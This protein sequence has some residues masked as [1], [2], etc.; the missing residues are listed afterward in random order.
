[1]ALRVLLADESSTIKK[2]IQLALQDFAVEVKTVHL[3]VDVL[4]VARQFKPD[5][6]LA[7]VLLQKRNGYEV[8]EDVKQNPSTSLVPVILMWSSFMEVDHD[9]IQHCG[10]DGQL[11]KPF[12]VDDLRQ[13]VTQLVPLAQEQPVA[14]FAHFSPQLTADF[15]LELESDPRI[16][17]P[18]ATARSESAPHSRSQSISQPIS[19]PVPKAPVQPPTRRH[20]MDLGAGTEIGGHPSNS[21]SVEPQKKSWTMDDFEDVQKFATP[22]GVTTSSLRSLSNDNGNSVQ[23][24]PPVSDSVSNFDNRIPQENEFP[25]FE[26]SSDLDSVDLSS[27]PFTSKTSESQQAHES[28]NPLDRFKLDPFDDHDEDFILADINQENKDLVYPQDYPV[29]NAKP[30]LRHEK[31]ETHPHTELGRVES[32]ESFQQRSEFGSQS[33][34]TNQ[35]MSQ[36]MEQIELMLPRI[37]EESVRKV[38]PDLLTS[39]ITREIEKVAQELSQLKS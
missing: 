19:Q 6:I 17:P 14:P 38:L 9:R 8:C 22:E 23:N 12:D 35:S 31:V 36:V 29:T 32:K 26:F 10:A 30:T 11:E 33:I 3:G 24:L 27:K 39:I 20:S 18:G 4:E 28:V 21:S 5:I 25:S 34:E 1:M 16:K 7:D 37:V 2:V 13:L 15:K